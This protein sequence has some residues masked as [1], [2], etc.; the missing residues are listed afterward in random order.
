MDKIFVIFIISLSFL[1]ANEGENIYNTNCL[2][3]HNSSSEEMKAPP[4]QKIVNKLKMIKNREGFV[5][6]VSDYI[7]NPSQRKGYCRTRAYKTF[8][9]MPSMNHLTEKESRA[10]SLWLYDTYGST[11]DTRYKYSTSCGKKRCCQNAKN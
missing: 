10:V 6:F 1:A 4:M 7:Q 9:V 11:G 2:V 3:C 8:G 5:D